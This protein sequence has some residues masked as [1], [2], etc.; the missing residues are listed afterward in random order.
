MDVT[1]SK[2]VIGLDQVAPSSEAYLPLPTRPRGP[3][4][5]PDLGPGFFENCSRKQA[6]SRSCSSILQPVQ[7]T[8]VQYLQAFPATQMR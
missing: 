3:E 4:P 7:D 2:C 6:E 5:E 8:E 1:I